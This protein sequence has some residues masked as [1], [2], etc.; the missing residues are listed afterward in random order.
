VG[1]LQ[2]RPLKDAQPRAEVYMVSGCD[3]DNPA[4]A[5]FLR[6]ATGYFLALP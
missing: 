4:L 5:H 2:F 3:N 1:H 6:M